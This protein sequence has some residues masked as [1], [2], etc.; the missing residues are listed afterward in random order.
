M[1]GV[2]GWFRRF[3]GGPMPLEGL[4]RVGGH[5]WAVHL[6]ELAYMADRPRCPRLSLLVVYE[7]DTP[8]SEPHSRHTEIRELGGGRFMHWGEHLI[9]STSDNSDPLVNGRSYSYSRAWWHYRRHYG[10]WPLTGATRGLRFEPANFQILDSRPDGIERD[11]DYSFKVVDA[12]LSRLPGG[13]DQLVG[14]SA[15]EIGP[16]HN[17]GTA[18]C[19]KALG[20]RVTVVDRFPPAWDDVYHPRLYAALH[21][22]LRQERPTWDR[23]PIRTVVER[24]DHEPVVTCIAAAAES[25]PSI[26]DGSIDLTFSN[27]VLE[28]SF[29]LESTIAEIGR[30]TRPGG[31]AV[32][33]LDHRDHRDF[34][35]PLEYLVL[36]DD[37]FEVIFDELHGECGNRL[38]RHEVEAL[39]RGSRFRIERVLVSRVADRRY[40]DRVVARL[41]RARGSRY[42][43]NGLQEIEDLSCCYL[44]QLSMANPDHAR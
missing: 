32:H 11:V 16:G 29:D 12:Y 43:D 4:W 41:R 13:R 5:A 33:Q 8:L 1:S 6:P 23:A 10:R 35:R 25:V 39:F 19:L 27:A 17:L 9:F 26:A 14:A 44:A 38:R 7:D 18:L 20:A 30:I 31:W 34:S 36:P 40:A 3:L 37:R 15:V 28:H 22:R 42:R 2:Q 21:D 24:G